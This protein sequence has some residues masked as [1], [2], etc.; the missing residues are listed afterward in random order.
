MNDGKDNN[1][2]EYI[3]Y[4]VAKSEEVFEAAR[5]LYDAGQWNSRV[6]R[7]YY[8]CF[9]IASALLLR[10]NIGAKSHGGGN[11]PVL[12]YRSPYRSGLRRRLPCLF[13]AAQLAGKGRL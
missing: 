5:I 12:R 10:R 9:Y 3:A 4:R 11:R 1:F 7:L 13:Q 6:N 8:A 2:E